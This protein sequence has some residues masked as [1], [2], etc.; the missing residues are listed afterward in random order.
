[1]KNTRATSM[2]GAV[3]GTAAAML[4]ALPNAAWAQWKWRDANGV[5]Q[6]TDRPPPA[7][8]PDSHILTRPAAARTPKVVPA[9]APTPASA[10]EVKP[11]A[12]AKAGDPEL[13][14]KRKKA[15]EQK[16]AERKVEE[17]KQAK[18]RSENCERARGYERS[19]QS[20]QRIVRTNEKGEREVLDDN[21]RAEE[22]QRTR[23]AIESNCR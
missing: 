17:E 18:V 10:P 3:L 15:E 20:G 1:M 6:Y 23:E 5:T 11:G 4:L 16:A 13:E 2:W 22:S 8:T 9:S 12:Q 19:L 21:A 7:G 14:A